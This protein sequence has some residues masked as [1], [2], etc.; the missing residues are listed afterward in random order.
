[1]ERSEPTIREVSSAYCVMGDNGA[2]TPGRERPVMAGLA[3]ILTQE[4]QKP[5]HTAEEIKDN[6]DEPHE[7]KK[8]SLTNNHLQ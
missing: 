5:E 7:I 4:L 3:R 8:K 2:G 1:M 6:L